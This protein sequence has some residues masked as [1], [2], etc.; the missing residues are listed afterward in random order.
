MKQSYFILSASIAAALA[1]TSVMAQPVAASGQALA[2]VNTAES[3]R[4]TQAVNANVVSAVAQSHLK[5][6]NKAKP[7]SQLADATQMNHLQLILKRSALRE[8]ALTQFM[9]DQHNPKSAK[10]Q[11]WLTPQQFGD[12]FGVADSDI[13]ATKAWLVS[14]GFTVHGVYPNKMQIDFSGTAGQVNRS[15]HT[16]ENNYKLANGTSHVAN[17]RDISIPS[18]LSAV[19]VGVA[20]L[21]DFH[22]KALLKQQK[23]MKL[24]PSGKGLALKPL[25]APVAVA[26]TGKKGQAI[27]FTN[28]A[29]GLVPNDIATMYNFKSLRTNGVVGTG[30]TIA[31]IED[32]DMV[33]ADWPNFV[34]QFNLVQYGGTFAQTHPVGPSQCDAPA[35]ATATTESG[36]T[37]L[38]AEW[39]A[40]VAPGAAIV[41]ATCAD[42][43]IDNFFGGVF[44]AGTN[45]INADV[46]PN[47]ISASYGFGEFFTD[48]ASK[49]AIDLMWA[50]A[51]AEGIS[52]FV[53]TGDSGS[54]PSF[55]GRLIN[56]YYGGT[57]VDANSFATS[58]NV[59][60]VGGTDTA[61][62]LDG[63]TSKYF[64]PTHSVVGGSALSYV[65]EIPW[66]QSCG[67]GVAAKSLGYSSAVDFCNAD[68]A[69]DIDPSRSPGFQ[70][71]AG[72]G[73]PSS[74]VRKPVW[75]RQI[76]NAA[77][78]QSRD[79]PDVSLFA[80]SF[81]G[82]TWAIDCTAKYPCSPDFSGEISITGG[83]SLASPMFAG[84]QALIDQGL[85]MRG[86]QA[87]Q[88]NAAPTL[89]A[90]AAN[91]YG[92]STGIAPASL[93]ACNSD[94]GATGTSACVFH[95][96]TRGSISS[97]CYDAQPLFTTPNCYFYTSIPE[98]G[99]VTVRVGLTTTDASPTTY[100]NTNK[101]FIAQPGWSFASGLGS[102]DTRNLLIAWRAF[103]NA[104]AAAPAATAALSK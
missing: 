83:T 66:N 71:E 90:L 49:T 68:V 2:G 80:G 77:R 92:G 36:E 31:V 9:A 98:N 44:A 48:T 17:A 27:S 22:P 85:V 54:N 88:G 55:N 94:N 13:Q 63:T 70:S 14:Q 10:F 69:G 104:P 62:V 23:A 67:N 51:D 25:N 52:V 35:T 56:S 15:F 87:N 72:S 91:E 81:A 38:D 96:I 79:L 26:K 84:I 28:G 18:A 20:G 42:T 21:N 89:Y 78:D 45:I 50:Q 97:N 29:R 103:V 12:A 8:A 47:V 43:G 58:T 37:V 24:D 75:Q 3:A 65:P 32:A 19:V 101:A 57:A 74:V 76:F 60:S 5:F 11:Q 102:V 41:V 16:Q 73:G 86:L 34:T 30:I 40:A 6:V 59:T 4:V 82:L 95:N 33:E 46:R 100:S 39:A 7:V 53:S 61:D 99:G 64:A 93:A 1:S